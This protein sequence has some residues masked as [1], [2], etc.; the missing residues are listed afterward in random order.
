MKTAEEIFNQ[1]EKELSYICGITG[2]PKA[3]II[4]LLTTWKEDICKKRDEQIVT[5]LN[6]IKHN[7]IFTTQAKIRKII[8]QLPEPT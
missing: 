6:P 1:I 8:E 7:W 5:E 3:K 4:N 2:T